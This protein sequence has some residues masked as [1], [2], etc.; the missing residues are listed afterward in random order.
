MGYMLPVLICVAWSLWAAAAIAATRARER[1]QST[2]VAGPA[3]VTIVPAIP[4][5]PLAARG[6]AV[7][8]DWAAYPWGTWTIGSLHAALSVCAMI[9]TLGNVRA[10]RRA[11][12]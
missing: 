5:F 10:M 6:L 3:A 12:R 7:A 2:P 11:T 8:I 4:I 9:W 1:E